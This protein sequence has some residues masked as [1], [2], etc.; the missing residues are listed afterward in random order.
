MVPCRV[1]FHTAA[2]FRTPPSFQQIRLDPDTPPL[3]DALLDEAACTSPTSLLQLS[4]APIDCFNIFYRLHRLALAISSQWI[5]KVNRLTFSN[6]LYETE[7]IILSVPDYSREF[8]DFDLAAKAEENE[9]EERASLAD[10]ASITE[11]LLAATQIFVYASL[12]EIPPNAKIFS[13]LL[14]RLRVAI[15]RPN[16][17]TIEIWTKAQNLHT[18]LWVLV[19]ASSVASGGWRRDWWLKKQSQAVQALEIESKLEL[20]RQLEGVAW[21]DV[22]FGDALEQTWEEM[23]RLTKVADS[24]EESMQRRQNDEEAPASPETPDAQRLAGRGRCDLPVEFE[25]GRWKVNGWYI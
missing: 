9:Y 24:R 5:R 19:V 21:T 11:A 25:N 13:I 14:E 18:L 8:L 7:Y 4:V 2:A 15:D 6:L 3:P 22:F 20:K 17:P 10:G 23:M 1:D 16:I 12:R